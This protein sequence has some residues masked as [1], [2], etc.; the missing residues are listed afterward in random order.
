MEGES[1]GRRERVR[2]G[3]RESGEESRKRIRRKEGS[4]GEGGMKGE[5]NKE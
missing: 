5:E 1:E 2:G 4:G 3:G